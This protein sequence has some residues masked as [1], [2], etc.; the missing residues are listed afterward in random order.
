MRLPRFTK[1]ANKIQQAAI[2]EAKP[3]TKPKNKNTLAPR[4]PRQPPS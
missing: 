1:L 3:N 4:G 2:T